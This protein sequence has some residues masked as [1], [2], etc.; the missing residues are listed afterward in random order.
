[1]SPRDLWCFGQWVDGAGLLNMEVAEE[2][3]VSP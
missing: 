2:L 1:M 3:G